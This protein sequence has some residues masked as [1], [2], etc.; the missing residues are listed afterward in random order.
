MKFQVTYLEIC[1]QPVAIGHVADLLG[2][3]AGII[4]DGAADTRYGCRAWRSPA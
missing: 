3:L 1:N 4:A 2:Q